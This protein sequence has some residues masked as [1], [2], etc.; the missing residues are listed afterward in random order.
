MKATKLKVEHYGGLDKEI[1]LSP[2]TIF[3]GTNEAG[4]SRIL[5]AIQLA[6]TGELTDPDSPRDSIKQNAE[7]FKLASTGQFDMAV[8]MTF[9]NKKSLDRRYV[10]GSGSEGKQTVSSRLTYSGQSSVTRGKS[11]DTALAITEWLRPDPD[12]LNI[13]YLASLTENKRRELIIDMMASAGEPDGVDFK[14]LADEI[15]DW[16]KLECETVKPGTPEWTL[17]SETL[18]ENIEQVRGSISSLDA[19]RNL[20]VIF[21]E[22]KKQIDT[23]LKTVEASI[24][25]LS[26]EEVTLMEPATIDEMEAEYELLTKAVNVLSEAK[27]NADATVQRHTSLKTRRGELQKQKKDFEETSRCKG[28]FGI[29]GGFT[30]CQSIANQDS[31]EGSCPQCRGSMTA[32]LGYLKTALAKLPQMKADA[33]TEI[34]MQDDAARKDLLDLQAS[35][36]RTIRDSRTELQALL[37]N[38]KAERPSIIDPLKAKVNE[39]TESRNVLIDTTH[40]LNGELGEIKGER[41]QKAEYE[42][43]V[44]A[45]DSGEGVCPLCNQQADP[46]AMEARLIE[47]IKALDIRLNNKTTEL[48]RVQDS[49]AHFLTLITE[50]QTAHDN[51]VKR[52]DKLVA[53]TMESIRKQG[54]ELVKLETA[55]QLAVNALDKQKAD[56]ETATEN[57]EREYGSALK[58]LIQLLERTSV[59]DEELLKLEGELADL[60]LPDIEDIKTKI[61]QKNNRLRELRGNIDTARESAKVGEQIAELNIQA[62]RNRRL[63]VIFKAL[64]ASVGAKGMQGEILK[65]RIGSFVD[66]VNEIV[67][68]MN[69]GKTFIIDFYDPRGNEVCTFK[70]REG[71]KLYPWETASRGERCMACIAVAIARMRMN[72]RSNCKILLVDNID[73]LDYQFTNN[74]LKVITAC[75]KAIQAGY[76]DNAFLAGVILPSRIQQ[77]L[78]E[79]MKPM[80]DVH[81]LTPEVAISN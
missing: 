48:K 18:L 79:W 17:M 74:L 57:N 50:A 45:M 13:Q 9:D 65:K 7:I 2:V 77:W 66:M 16:L 43:I 51:E 1:D 60:K 24:R 37:D 5:H 36:I 75:C 46:V 41:K 42:T 58:G 29:Q 56:L 8:G 67:G 53:D 33:L 78:E 30:P 39:L 81:T 20:E 71:A 10:A 73:M 21:K 40:T 76:I 12:G 23:D 70:F 52:I 59:D 11:S 28:A 32:N 35:E 31:R 63:A 47:E 54:M 19:L 27:G 3:T 49:A 61:V 64:A 68:W 22:R 34:G 69:P 44:K 15:I 55:H 38:T 25:K 62:E 72:T 80:V 26:E 4:K 14:K 6:E